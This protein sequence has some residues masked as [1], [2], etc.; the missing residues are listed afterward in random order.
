MELNMRLD[1]RVPILLAALSLAA[2][3][4]DGGNGP[5]TGGGPK[6]QPPTGPASTS[7]ADLKTWVSDGTVRREITRT[8]DSQTNAGVHQTDRSITI[9]GQTIQ[10]R[11]L[12]TN[13]SGVMVAYNDGTTFIYQA[14]SSLT[15]TASPTGTYVGRADAHYRIAADGPIIYGRGDASLSV[16]SGTGVLGYGFGIFGQDSDVD[17]HIYGDGA[18][19]PETDLFSSIY[20]ANQATIRIDGAVDRTAHATV[21]GG[22]YG[23]EIDGNQVAIGTISADDQTNEFWLRGGFIATPRP[24]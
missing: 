18:F 23:T 15:P 17:V 9:D 21:F 5:A 20:S 10:V 14:A 8:P 3:V 22:F 11:M 13:Q 19:D 4:S 24:E 6:P 16:N 7:V 2:C 1:H 12:D